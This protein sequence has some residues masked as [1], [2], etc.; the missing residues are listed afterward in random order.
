MAS[1][2]KMQPSRNTA[3]NNAKRMS[4]LLRDDSDGT[5]NRSAQRLSDLPGGEVTTTK[6]SQQISGNLIWVRVERRL[7]TPTAACRG[8]GRLRSAPET[9]WGR[10][11][12]I[13]ERPGASQ[14]R[15]WSDLGVISE[16]FGVLG[17]PYGAVSEP[18]MPSVWVIRV[19]GTRKLSDFVVDILANADVYECFNG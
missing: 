19:F 18:S 10:S 9:F 1:S 5:G 4:E 6:T 7:A 11:E 2:E 15:F 8:L 3:K 12:G 13:W 14:G 17:W 16:P